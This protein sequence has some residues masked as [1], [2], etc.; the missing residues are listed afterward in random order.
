MCCQQRC[1]ARIARGP[2]DRASGTGVKFALLLLL[3]VATFSGFGCAGAR[4]G[5][6]QQAP[7]MYPSRTSSS[8]NASRSPQR[9]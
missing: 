2:A 5:V 1:M 7:A 9:T 4:A 3:L 6:T 8:S